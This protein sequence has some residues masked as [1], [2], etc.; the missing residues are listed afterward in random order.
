MIAAINDSV[1]VHTAVLSLGII[2]L[3]SAGKK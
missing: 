1:S 3:I 2:V